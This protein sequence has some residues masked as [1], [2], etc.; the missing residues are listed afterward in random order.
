[1]KDER[2]TKAQLIDELVALRE[3]VE[4]LT[5]DGSSDIQES[6][7]ALS[8]LTG[9]GMSPCH[10][11]EFMSHMSS[12]VA[13]YTPVDDGMDFV[14]TGANS[15]LALIED[16]ELEDIIGRRVTEV[17]PGVMEFG[18]LD[19]LQDVHRTGVPR[20]HPVRQYRDD[21]IQGWRENHVFKARD[22]SVVAI[23]E[24]RTLEKKKEADLRES[25]DR[26]RTL[27]DNLT[28][29]VFVAEPEGRRLVDCNA[30]ACTLLGKT[31]DEILG[32]DAT[33]LHPE[34]R[35][36][37]TMRDFEDHA[38]GD[39]KVVESEVVHKDGSRIPVE[40]NSSMAVIKG[41][42][43]VIGLF[44]DV[45]E[46]YMADQALRE[47]EERYR[48][49]VET[50]PV[51]VSVSDM[52]GRFLYVSDRAVEL[53][54]HD[55]PADL[56]G[57]NS[58][59]TVHPDDRD[60][61]MAEFAGIMEH[62][63][64]WGMEFRL[65]RKDGS[66][67][68]AQINASALRSSGGEVNAIIM[69]LRD[70]T[71]ER[72]SQDRVEA[73]E[74]KY[75][76]LFDSMNEGAALH[77]VIVDDDGKAIDYRI[78][79]INPAYER[80]VGLTREKA[81]GKLASELYGTG[82]APYLNEFTGVGLS[83][84]ATTMETYFHA[85]D[86]HY[87]ISIFSP[88]P[89][90]F[91]TVFQD[92][93]ERKRSQ[94]SI[95]QEKERL[96]VTLQSIGDGVIATDTIGRVILL[97]GIA[98]TLTGWSED[99]AMGQQISE[100]FDIINESTGKTQENPIDKVMRL[101]K[102][103]GLANNT[104]LISRNGERRII[105]DS[106]AP[107]RDMEGDII[108]VVL[109]FRD[110][111]EKR[112]NAEELLKSQKLES[113]GVLAGGI[114]HDFNNILTGVMGSISLAGDTVSEGHPALS[115][116]EEAV[117]ATTRARE[118]TQQLL[119]FSKGGTPLTEIVDIND[120]LSETAS[121][122]CRGSTM[123]CEYS[124]GDVWPVEVD[125]GQFSQV[126]NNLVINADQASPRGSTLMISSSN[127]NIEKGTILPLEPGKYVKVVFEDQGKGIPRQLLDKVFDPYFTTKETSTGLGLT[128]VYSIVKKHRGH[129]VAYSEEGK[130]T[131]FS[132]YLPA[133]VGATVRTREPESDQ[134]S[135]AGTVLLMD[136]DEFI[137][138]VTGK[139]LEH[140]GYTPSFASEGL[141][142]LEMY[143][144]SVESGTPYD[145]VI[146]DLTIPGG[147][148]GEET[149]KAINE[150]DGSARVI[151]SSGYS[152][153]PIIAN[154]RDHGFIDYLVKPYRMDELG[155][156]LRR[157]LDGNGE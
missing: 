30:S 84:E 63:N 118:L 14:F 126:V 130:G 12:A 2:K 52:K 119:T 106:G 9:P 102:V 51:A 128:S 104:I 138:K 86:I 133:R 83:G 98:Q 17:F 152:F 76:S 21:R 70:I 125:P 141:E 65:L 137:R 89:G 28:D 33:Q 58:F 135:G 136:D 85:H 19:I 123:G 112:R 92:I 27:F 121:F 48:T 4:T 91:A 74:R 79:D 61:A 71:D 142:A 50:T 5:H 24:D 31:R 154:H 99:E 29:A 36:E 56:V 115:I 150:I 120:V 94:D 116:L 155:R 109:V 131:S 156:V 88:G 26:F 101:G 10:L 66:S 3:R 23:Y 151:V 87:L 46:H 49:L 37:Q 107:I 72:E 149:V 148:G 113:L 25:E 54:G 100:V 40:I 13:I 57:R 157:V 78:I 18:F 44:R 68:L 144:A 97:N 139:L 38:R 95:F 75:R 69:T 90:Q 35:V 41:E 11:E 153:D 15:S 53:S 124:L 55:S 39:R 42:T 7:E 103:V 73:S 122:A 111:T 105:A 16:V 81:V 8:S 127:T 143:R 134:I 132:I 146:L 1:M 22:G 47:S 45:S 67:Y 80:I 96:K 77:D 145:V 20:D 60:R 43:M 6:A 110:V 64:M 59:E 82:V 129:I 147:M 140:L 114:A 117:R 32:M 62:G 93:T 108:G 34:D